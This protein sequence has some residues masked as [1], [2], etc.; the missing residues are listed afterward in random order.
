M[1][2]GNEA[3]VVT[4][5]L[6]RLQ[7]RARVHLQARADMVLPLENRLNQATYYLGL[8]CGSRTWKMHEAV[9][10]ALRFT[11]VKRT[12]VEQES[13]VGQDREAGAGP[14]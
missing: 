12:S 9:T 7:E 4:P 3:V 11:R 5:F 6:V 8:I 13:R 2:S 14:P 10:G 1:A